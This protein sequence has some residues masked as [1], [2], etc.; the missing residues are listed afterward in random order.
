MEPKPK[1]SKTAIVAYRRNV[2]QVSPTGLQAMMELTRRSV[3][4]E[5]AIGFVLRQEGYDIHPDEIS[6]SIS[7]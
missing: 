7:G 1:R 5:T 4:S 3:E 6:L 2:Y